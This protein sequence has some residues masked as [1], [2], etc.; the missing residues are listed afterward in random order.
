MIHGQTTKLYNIMTSPKKKSSREKKKRTKKTK[1]TT[2]AT[3]VNKNTIKINIGAGKGGGGGGGGGTTV[4]A[5]GP[6]PQ[7]GWAH[8]YPLTPPSGL[9]Q[10]RPMN[11]FN[12][13]YQHDHIPPR[14][15][16]SS[17]GDEDSD[18]GS[19]ITGGGGSEPDP[20]HENFTNQIAALEDRIK[21]NMPP[22]YDHVFRHINDQMAM[23][24]G[25]RNEMQENLRRLTEAHETLRQ[26]MA[27]GQADSNALLGQ[28]LT[29]MRGRQDALNAQLGQQLKELRGRHDAQNAQLGQ[30]LTGLRGR[31]D[32]LEA[33]VQENNGRMN[34]IAR[35][36]A[37]S[38][39]RSRAL[40][41]TVRG[42]RMALDHGRAVAEELRQHL[43]QVRDDLGV[44]I[45]LQGERHTENMLIHDQRRR[46][47]LAANQAIGTIG[48]NNEVNRQ[49]NN[50]L[51]EEVTADRE[52]TM[53]RLAALEAQVAGHVGALNDLNAANATNAATT[54]AHAAHLAQAVQ[55]VGGQ[56]AHHENALQTGIN[57]I[58]E[59]IGV[60][61]TAH[62]NHNAQLSQLQQ[63]VVQAG[64]YH[65]LPVPPHLPEQEPI[66]PPPPQQQDAP[67]DPAMEDAAQPAAEP[68]AP[69]HGHNLRPRGPDGRAIIRRDFGLRPRGEDGRAIIRR[70]FGLRPRG[71]D[72]RAIIRRDFGLRP[73]GEDGRVI[74][75]RADHEQPVRLNADGAN[76]PQPPRI[77][78]MS[79]TR[80]AIMQG[81]HERRNHTVY[82]QRS[83]FR[84]GEQQQQQAAPPP[85][86]DDEE[87][88]EGVW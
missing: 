36:A 6:P 27:R 88:V 23:E 75:R 85:P 38:L 10:F 76:A 56:V 64:H 62:Q 81:A 59:H 61:A 86:P 51:D 47:I 87:D 70:D 49:E 66:L 25:I 54:A 50:E 80:S 26:G 14:G 77:P 65:N 11:P 13:P 78:R 73:R 55:H 48:H 34:T 43:G 44:N 32:A 20:L 17:R 12:N 41:R 4:V 46:D 40:G 5:S 69:A 18:N 3:N 24:G 35:D 16:R 15:G 28:Q 31:G 2:R 8:P 82:N 79:G 1:K 63:D 39:T 52:R 21:N 9:A 53:A 84:N 58:H 71:E 30:Q 33:R 72:G 45:G 37:R 29:D 67:P 68:V 60:L 7:Q 57:N 83:E 22:N 74:R 19:G 42:H